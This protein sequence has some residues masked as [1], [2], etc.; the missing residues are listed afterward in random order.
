M[1]TFIVTLA[2]LLAATAAYARFN[3]CPP[4]FCPGLN[5]GGGIVLPTGKMLMSDGT[6]FILKSD[7]TSKMCRAGGC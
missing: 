4:G 2:L 6:S 1:K 5:N 3:G 7:G